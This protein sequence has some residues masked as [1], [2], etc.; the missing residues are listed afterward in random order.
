MSDSALR[1]ALSYPRFAGPPRLLIFDSTYYV[2][3]DVIEA[4][5][6]LGCQVARL[7]A[8]GKGRGDDRF[9][10]DLLTALC[11]H[12]PDFILTINHLGFDEQG[13]LAGLL[14]EYKV[15][16]A[17]WFVDHPMPILLGAEQ[18][19][20]PT[21][22]VFCLER[23]ALPWLAAAGFRDPVH[24]PTAASRACHPDRVSPMLRAALATPLCFLGDSWWRKG[25][26]EPPGWAVAAAREHL[27]LD[28]AQ[29]ADLSTLMGSLSRAPIPIGPLGPA[30]P[31][32]PTGMREERARALLALT[33]LA[34]AASAERVALIRALRPLGVRVHGDASWS[35]LVPGLDHKGPLDPV[36][37]APALYAGVE[38]NVN[39]TA[40]HMPTAVNQRV[41]DVP[42]AGGFL[43]TDAQE[44][45]LACFEPG[46]EVVAYRSPEEAAEM[47]R[48]YLAHPEERAGIAARA[49]ARVE[50]EHRYPHRLRRILQTMRARFA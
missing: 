46:R 44:D 15:P 19:A 21:C 39:I 23:T 6:E 9:V 49:R 47:A 2:T 14:A 38:V 16:V 8:Q 40:V 28:K 35:R 17:S 31:T 12:H 37:A 48:H 50:A 41:W 10:V 3:R 22:Q 5:A 42:A 20:T 4:A 45:A 30:G 32:G 18:N 34:Q 26:D 27:R 43:L 24:L 13:V 33:A 1:R 36:Q 25:F 11:A 7:P 29:V